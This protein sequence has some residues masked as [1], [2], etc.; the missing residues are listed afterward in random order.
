MGFGSHRDVLARRRPSGERRGWGRPSVWTLPRHVFLSFPF[1]STRVLL[2]RSGF[3]RGCGKG[4]GSR[5]PSPFLVRSRRV[6]PPFLRARDGG[7]G[8]EHATSPPHPPLGGRERQRQR[9]EGGGAAAA[10]GKDHPTFLPIS[11]SIGIA[12]GFERE[13]PPP[14]PPSLRDGVEDGPN[15]RGVEGAP[16][17][18]LPQE[19]GRQRGREGGGPRALLE[20]AQGGR[21]TD[22]PTSGLAGE[23]LLR[24]RVLDIETRKDRPSVSIEAR[25]Q[26]RWP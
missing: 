15:E 21:G 7:Y 16:P 22:R 12:S 20:W 13:I 1:P 17:P 4:G 24:T 10:V 6:P 11:L 26:Q 2:S 18:P 9:G 3:V 19:A 8:R 25:N 5:F 23:P 14:F